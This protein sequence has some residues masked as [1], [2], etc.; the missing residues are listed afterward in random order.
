MMH[1]QKLRKTT[2][3][4]GVATARIFLGILFLMT[5]MMKL[6]IPALADAFI[7]QLA[8]ADLPLQEL[9]RW[10]V[11]IVEVAVGGTLLRGYQ[12]RISALVVL[13]LMAVAT[14]VHLLIDDPALFPLQPSAPIIPLVAIA[15]AL[16]ILVRGGG[17]GSMDLKSKG[18]N[19]E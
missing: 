6:F 14:Y 5:G 3:N 7:G 17:A 13:G 1:C 2:S 15:V 16:V 12:S 8:A 10:L 11:P 4:R 18:T 19:H 9:N